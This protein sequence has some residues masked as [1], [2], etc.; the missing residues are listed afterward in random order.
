MKHLKVIAFTHKH[1]ELRDLGSL[2]ID[3]EELNARMRGL[4]QAF[5]IAEIFYIGTCNRVEFVFYGTHQ[6][7]P[8][9][10]ASFLKK[11]NFCVP[12]VQL[13][14]FLNQV[15]TY[16]GIDALRHLFRMSCSLESLVVGQETGEG[17]ERDVRIVLFVRLAAGH[18][19]DDAL[20]DRIR[21]VIRE[22][23]SPHHVPKVIV[24]VDDIPRTISGKITELA[25]REVIHGRPV[26]NREALANP[27]AL[28]LFRDL[29]EL[30]R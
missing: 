22:G 7:T 13:A 6:L 14:S 8:D 17:S 25:V 28:E 27:A 15:D 20:R 2:V 3:N 10:I 18:R 5:D 23:A 12:E 21:R 1:V 19:L 30:R 16:E 29:P 11:L 9:F 26:R 4:K 24:A